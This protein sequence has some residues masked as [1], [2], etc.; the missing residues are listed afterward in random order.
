MAVA[1]MCIGGRLGANVDLDGT[2][3]GDVWGRLWG[4]SLGRFIVAV[5]PEHE[6]TFRELMRGHRITVLGEVLDNGA[7]HVTDGEDDVLHVEVDAMVDA[8]QATLA[9]GGVQHA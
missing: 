3:A 8:W 7:L 9:L 2:G 1:E 5:S 6:T 4:E